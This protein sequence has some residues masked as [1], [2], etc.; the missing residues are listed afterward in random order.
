M[1]RGQEDLRPFMTKR[2][3]VCELLRDAPSYLRE[4]GRL[5]F[6]SLEDFVSLFDAQSDSY[7]P[8]AVLLYHFE[9]YSDRVYDKSLRAKADS[10][11]ASF[12]PVSIQKQVENIFSVDKQLNLTGDC[13]QEVLVPQV[14]A[15]ADS[16]LIRAASLLGALVEKQQYNAA[17]CVAT[18][19]LALAN[20][21]A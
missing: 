2:L 14:L 7:L 11:D 12:I 16:D 13:E 21:V 4:P 6:T 10:V 15:L 17:L 3:L 5:P 1:N 18:N 20:A 8:H 19:E 9:A